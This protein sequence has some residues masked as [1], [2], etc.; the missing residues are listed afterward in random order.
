MEIAGN[1]YTAHLNIKCFMM[2][3]FPTFERACREGNFFFL[4]LYQNQYK[5]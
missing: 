5:I 1:Q 2:E 3:T 4:K